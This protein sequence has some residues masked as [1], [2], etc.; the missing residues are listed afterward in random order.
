MAEQAGEKS[1]EASDQ[2]KEDFRK[3]GQY[4]KARDAGSV[5]AMFAVIATLLGQ[6]RTISAA[7]DELFGRTL[8]N[9]G[10]I[11]HGNGSYS[12]DAATHAFVTIAGPSAIAAAIASAGIGIVQSGMRIDLALLEFK[13][14]RLNPLG[15]LGQMFSPKHAMV[16][17][18]MSLL[19]I[20]VV[21]VVA[22]RV[23]MIELPSLLASGR[24]T[25]DGGLDHL[26][27]VITRVIVSSLVALAII[28]VVDY[29]QSRFS[30]NKE[31]MMTRQEMV[32]EGRQQNGDPKI[33]ARM[34][35]RARAMAKRRA[36]NK[37]KEAD[38][39]VTNPTHVAVALRYG[40]KD[41]A[42]IV[43]AKGIDEHALQIRAEARKHGIP[44]LEN[45]PLARALEA[46]VPVG[47]AVPAM[48]FAAVARVLAFVYKLRGRKTV[49]RAPPSRGTAR[50]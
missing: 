10:A 16:E 38:V 20:G 22:Y 46:T 3:R 17:T 14:D 36:M 40:K 31:M 27:N 33:K 50:A 18:T 23:L 34:R 32:E 43:V 7:I 1:F 25:L 9:L 42:P 6:R 39:I 45:R 24:M 30:L 44:I 49:A 21:S 8:G 11:T 28:A 15:K 19:R 37:I 35:Q 48:H 26:I 47:H 4:A 5:F 41:P 2:R 13:P 12:F 29:A